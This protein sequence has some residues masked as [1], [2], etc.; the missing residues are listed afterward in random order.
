MSSGLEVKVAFG[1]EIGQFADDLA[2][3]RIS[4]FREFPYLYD[5]SIEYERGYIQR[6]IDSPECAFVLVLDQN[7]VVGASTAQP[8]IHEIDEF[9]KPFIDQGY[10][11]D[12]VFYLAESV[13]LPEYRG[14]GLGHRFFDERE[15]FANSLRSFKWITFCAVDRPYDHP[16]R[17]SQYHPHDIF[18]GK[19]GYVKHPELKAFLPWQEIGEEGESLKSLTFWLKSMQ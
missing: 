18:W 7:K 13:L 2:R 1:P 17:P 12:E 15:K 19:R 16:L 14:R 9:K 6:Y 11:L 3:L 8:M 10:H 5:G 4:V